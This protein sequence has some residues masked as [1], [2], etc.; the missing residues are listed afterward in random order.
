[1]SRP[2]PA[3]AFESRTPSQEVAAA[4]LPRPWLTTSPNGPM[5]PPFGNPRPNRA[6]STHGRYCPFMRWVPCNECDGSGFVAGARGGG[7]VY[8][9]EF[10]TSCGGSGRE[11]V[12][13]PESTSPDDQPSTWSDPTRPEYQERI[14]DWFW[15]KY[16][17]ESDSL[18]GELQRREP[19]R[20]LKAIISIRDGR[21]DAVRD[22]LPIWFRTLANDPIDTT[23]MDS[24]TADRSP[25]AAGRVDS[26]SLDDG[27]H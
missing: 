27:V 3:A 6:P 24:A 10:C 12:A 20:Y 18:L 11:S 1:M 5:D 22:H 8:S 26:M 9:S 7:G 25:N 17:V 13:P 23:S 16:G 15:E 14:R 21:G 19:V 2:S 4:V